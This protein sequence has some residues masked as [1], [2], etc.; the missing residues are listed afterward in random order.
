[1]D[2]L[3]SRIKAELERV[4]WTS[5]GAHIKTGD[6]RKIASQAFRSL[7]DRSKDHVFSLCEELLEQRSWPMKVIAFGFAY[8]VCRQYNQAGFAVF[9]RW[10]EEYVRGWGDCDDFCTHAFGEL[11]CQYPELSRKTLLWTERRECWLRRAAAVVLIPSIRRGKYM[12]TDPLQ[13]ADLLMQD[14]H[15]LVRQ[16][17]G[18]MLK[19]LFAKEPDL[20][21]TYLRKHRAVMPRVAFRCA[22]EKLGEERRRIL[23][24]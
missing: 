1:M 20:V 7:G 13:V 12:E 11:I 5:S 24:Q 15:D 6:V 18:W 4:S 22:L 3:V 10:L 9:Q 21:F 2:N 14:E 17:Y 19:E 23:M 8:R 16:G